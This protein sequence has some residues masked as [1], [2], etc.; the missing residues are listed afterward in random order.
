MSGHSKWSSIKHQKG[1]ADAKRGKIFTKLTQEIIVAVRDGDS[2]PETNS[3]LRLA[4]QRARDNSMPNDNIERAIKRGSGT[5]EGGELT[6]LTMEG[7]GPG[8]VAVMVQ[9]LTDNH[10]RTVQ[11]VRHI[12]SHSGG[13]LGEKGSVAWNFEPKGFIT[14]DSSGLDADALA[15]KAIDAGAE[16]VQE[17]DE[18]VEIYTRPDQLEQVRKTL[19][20]DNVTI[21]SAELAMIA[22]N[23]VE[24]DERTALQTLRLLD[25][26]EDMDD[27]Q[28]VSS[29]ADF[30][31]EALEKY[32]SQLQT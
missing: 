31:A 9:C 1:A 7:Y 22:K 16:D 6:E 26:L 5:L 19:E 20:D 27:I 21:S 32:R 29:N 13:N 11:E 2:N 3:R 10:N 30:P 28:R 17:E 4:I 14:I 12:F 24:L 8:G 25:K 23:T 18:S 15:L